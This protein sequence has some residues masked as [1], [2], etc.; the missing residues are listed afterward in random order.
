MLVVEVIS[1]KG[2]TA[3]QADKVRLDALK[4]GVDAAKKRL[5]TEKQRQR[6]QK[7]Q[8]AL[9]KAL[10]NFSLTFPKNSKQEN[11]ILLFFSPE[12]LL[13]NSNTTKKTF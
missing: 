12:F 2:P 11:L 4:S 1:P 9:Q 6:V 8:K 3:N 10:I 5:D 13:K 7:A